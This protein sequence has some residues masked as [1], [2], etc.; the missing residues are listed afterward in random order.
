MSEKIKQHFQELSELRVPTK[1]VA[2][3]DRTA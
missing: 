1:R 3:S 2:Y